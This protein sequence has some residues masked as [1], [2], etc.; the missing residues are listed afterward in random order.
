MSDTK[1]NAPDSAAPRFT[2]APGFIVRDA[3][4]GDRPVA[5]FTFEDE[6]E[7]HAQKANGHHDT[8]VALAAKTNPTPRK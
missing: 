1:T 4:N 3:M 8:A 5:G 7:R 2:V 6:A